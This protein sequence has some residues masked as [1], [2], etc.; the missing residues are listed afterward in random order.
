MDIGLLQDSPAREG[1]KPS[2]KVSGP[3]IPEPWDLFSVYWLHS[4]LS[5][6]APIAWADTASIRPMR[7][8]SAYS[9]FSAQERLH[10][11]QKSASGGQWPC[12][13]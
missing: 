7:T 11:G 5:V 4:L 2:E 9:H 1:R 3:L 13:I 12:L 8:C 10:L 6:S